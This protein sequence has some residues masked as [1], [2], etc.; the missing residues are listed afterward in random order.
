MRC[1]VLVIGLRG[2]HRGN[3]RCI[4]VCL[5][6]KHAESCNTADARLQCCAGG[7]Q[8]GSVVQH[9]FQGSSLLATSWFAAL[10]S[11][12][13]TR[14]VVRQMSLFTCLFWLHLL[15]LT[16]NAQARTGTTR[17]V[18]PF[19]ARFRFR[20]K[21]GLFRW[22]SKPND[23]K[24][25]AEAGLGH[26]ERQNELRYVPHTL[27]LR[28][29]ASPSA[30]GWSTAGSRG[31]TSG[32]RPVFLTFERLATFWLDRASGLVAAASRHSKGDRQKRGEVFQIHSASERRCLMR[33]MLRLKSTST[34]FEGAE[35]SY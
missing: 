20:L 11:Q 2:Q 5:H 31:T 14:L 3:E 27:S 30:D 25:V 8:N 21:G 18:D 29:A 13:E 4:G 22:Q 32:D 10:S 15:H 23:E 7:L 28:P 19:S 33:K 24:T 17:D 1:E 16:K 34:N 12:L 26:R 35:L 6:R 9:P